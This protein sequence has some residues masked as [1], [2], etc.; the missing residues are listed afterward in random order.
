MFLLIQVKYSF[1][2]AQQDNGFVSVQSGAVSAFTWLQQ[3]KLSFIE[4]LIIS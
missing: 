3:I 1:Y 2:K 4:L